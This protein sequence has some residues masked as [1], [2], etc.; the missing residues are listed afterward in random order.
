[1]SS[2]QS[3]EIRRLTLFPLHLT[4]VLP[5]GDLDRYKTWLV[6]KWFKQ[7]YKVDYLETFSPVIKTTTIRLLS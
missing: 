5:S 4:K 7:Q 6:A 3:Q 1:M 2:T